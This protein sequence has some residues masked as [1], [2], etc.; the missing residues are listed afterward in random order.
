MCTSLV[1][2]SNY[3]Q[4][5]SSPVVYYVVFYLIMCVCFRHWS[6]IK[7]E[8]QRSFDQ[9]SAEFTLEEIVVL[10]LDHYAER[11]C[12]ISGAASKELSIEQVT[13]YT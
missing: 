12:E 9:S 13:E 2:T 3:A 6:Q 1:F 11:I 4:A 8:V 7:H 10:G 5:Q